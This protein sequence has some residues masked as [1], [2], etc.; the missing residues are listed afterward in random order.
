MNSEDHL[1]NTM[2]VYFRAMFYL[3]LHTGFSAQFCVR[4]RRSRVKCALNLLTWAWK[5][6]RTGETISRTSYGKKANE[7][8][9][10][11]FKKGEE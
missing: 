8:K 3:E 7:K 11:V 2:G 9:R 4:P 1:F 5:L 10:T 6:L